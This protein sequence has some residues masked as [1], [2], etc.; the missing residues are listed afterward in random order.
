MERL[1]GKRG[2]GEGLGLSLLLG[3]LAGAGRESGPCGGPEGAESHSCDECPSQG[4]CPIE[5]L[6]RKLKQGQAEVGGADGTKDAGLLLADAEITGKKAQV[7]HLGRVVTALREK[8]DQMAAAHKTELDQFTSR[9][10]AEL[11]HLA[12]RHDRA[13]ENY[14]QLVTTSREENRELSGNLESALQIIGNI[15]SIIASNSHKRPSREFLTALREELGM[16]PLEK[17]KKTTAS[18][19]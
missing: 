17:P 12:R 3:L 14:E 10:K 1:F 18:A 5:S 15:K 7:G 13:L 8:I 6:M 9:N 4:M 2:M 19:T 16:P 11:D